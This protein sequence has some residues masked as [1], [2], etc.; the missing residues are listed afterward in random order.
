M[1]SVKIDDIFLEDLMNTSLLP[2]IFEYRCLTRKD[3]ILN[4]QFLQELSQ[5]INIDSLEL[6]IY[7][8]WF[9]ID[10]KYY[11]FKYHYIFEEL[12]M[13]K[14]FETFHVPCV[15]HKIVKNRGKIG[16]ISENF[17]KSHC[18]YKDYKSAIPNNI[19]CPLS[20]VRYNEII[21]S[22]MNIFDYQYYLQLISK[23][24]SID[25]LFGQ[26]DH[27]AYNIMFEIS[28]FNFRLAPMFDNGNIFKE[29]DYLN[30]YILNLVLVYFHL[31]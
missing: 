17:R 18:E 26:F 25:I 1:R 29:A 16:I 24:I 15:R 22:E 7:H 23:I 3:D 13:E 28:D 4:S 27:H 30:T 6:E 8:N 14:I 21:K 10:N 19:D 9:L 11:Y 2:D 5:K 12:L 31:V 20:I